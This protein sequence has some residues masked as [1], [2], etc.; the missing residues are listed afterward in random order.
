MEPFFSTLLVG[1]DRAAD[2]GARSA[3]RRPA[4]VKY[5]RRLVLDS[6][7]C[8]LV[9]GCAWRLIPHDLAPWDVAYRWVSRLGRGRHLGSGA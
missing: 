1:A 5:D 4:V 7:L 6:I 2:S 8:V 3:R 9:S